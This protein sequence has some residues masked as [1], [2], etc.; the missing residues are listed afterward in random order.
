LSQFLEQAM[1]PER[2]MFPVGLNRKTITDTVKALDELD[3]QRKSAVARGSS[4]SPGTPAQ[5][6]RK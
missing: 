5:A 4:T 3:A 2:G 6:S 1:V